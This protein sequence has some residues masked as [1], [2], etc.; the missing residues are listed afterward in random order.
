MT[1]LFYL[2]SPLATLFAFLFLGDIPSL[3]TLI[4]GVSA[5]FGTVIVAKWGKAST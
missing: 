1:S 4:G 5:I 2:V 3:S